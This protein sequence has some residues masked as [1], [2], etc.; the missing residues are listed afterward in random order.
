MSKLIEIFE[1]VEM[2]ERDSG[3]EVGIPEVA[4][5]VSFE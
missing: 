4:I 1:M 2:I 5:E 3:N